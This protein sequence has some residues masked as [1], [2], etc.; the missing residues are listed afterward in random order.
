MSINDTRYWGAEMKLMTD[1]RKL[2]TSM[3][4]EP[5]SPALVPD[6][7]KNCSVESRKSKVESQRGPREIALDLRPS[8]FDRQLRRQPRAVGA[9]HPRQDQ[10]SPHPSVLARNGP[11]SG[12]RRST[13]CRRSGA[14]RS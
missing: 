11:P 8:P 6:R 12:T 2:M 1:L 4:L 5:G 10:R 7:R 14:R 13:G 9:E 3:A